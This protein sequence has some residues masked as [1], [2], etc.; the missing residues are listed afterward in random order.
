MITTLKNICDQILKILPKNNK[1]IHYSNKKSFDQRNYKVDFKKI[2]KIKIKYKYNLNKG[3][4]EILHRLK[5][6]KS[7]HKFIKKYSNS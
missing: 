4:K 5:I 1:Y 3:I 7:H 6:E 2:S